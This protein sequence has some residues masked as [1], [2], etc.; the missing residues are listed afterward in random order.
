MP[1]LKRWTWEPRRQNLC[2]ISIHPIQWPD[3]RYHM[4]IQSCIQNSDLKTATEG[5]MQSESVKPTLKTAPF[6]A[7][8][9]QTPAPSSVPAP[10]A[11]LRPGLELEN[12][13]QSFNWNWISRTCKVELERQETY[14]VFVWKE[15]SCTK[16]TGHSS[17][18][19]IWSTKL[20][21]SS[22]STSYR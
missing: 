6:T 10:L 11:K 1:I 17:W 5:S 9:D 20:C 16:V 2:Q 21:S 8:M 7:T 4:V 18:G 22:S 12:I 19:S 13:L 3:Y 14:D 15:G